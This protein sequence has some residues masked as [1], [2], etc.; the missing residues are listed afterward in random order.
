MGCQLL[1][2]NC[3]VKDIAI[4]TARDIEIMLGISNIETEGTL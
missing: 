2:F 1:V 4:N 3:E